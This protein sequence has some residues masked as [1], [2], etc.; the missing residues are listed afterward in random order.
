MPGFRNT[1]R[2]GPSRS[3]SEYNTVETKPYYQ[4]HDL[5]LSR[6]SGTYLQN[7]KARER[8]L[9]TDRNLLFCITLPRSTPS[10]STP[11][12]FIFKS[13]ASC[14]QWLQLRPIRAKS[15]ADQLL[16]LFIARG[17]LL[18]GHTCGL[19]VR[20]SSTISESG[21]ARFQSCKSRH[22]RMELGQDE[23]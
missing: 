3:P 7:P 9:A 14:V 20:I 6:L 12:T 4:A 2:V 19:V 23:H 21:E 1:L 10:T 8:L 22:A 11:A 5:S 16:E 15:I 18:D 17:S 13:L